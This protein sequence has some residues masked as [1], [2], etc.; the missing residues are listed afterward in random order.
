MV[1][2]G[3]DIKNA[4]DLIFSLD[5]G[6]KTVIGI[7]GIYENEKF[8]VI[9][10]SIKEHNRRNMYD[11]QIHDIEG[12]TK[13]VK[14]VKE[15]LEK[16]LEISLKK[17]SIAAAGRALKT[18]RLRLDKDIDST[19][20]IDNNMIKALELEAVQKSQESIDIEM[21]D[22]NL[23]YYS[24]GHSVI[25]YYLDNDFIER[26]EGHKGRKIGVDLLATFLPKVV[27]DSLYVVVNRAGLE[28]SNITLEPIAAINIAIK[29][30][31]RLLNLALVDIGAGTSD[32]AI[33][34]DGT[35]IAYA[36]AAIAGDEITENISKNYLLDFDSSEEL[37]VKLNKEK[38]HKFSDIVGI[39]YSCSSEEIISKIEK[40]IDKLATEIAKR[41]L[42]YNVKAPSA[43]FL[44]GGSSQIPLL[45]KYIAKYL[46]LPEERVVVRDLN[47]IENIEGI[48]KL[49][50]GPDMITPIGI[51]VEG[52]NNKDEN[53][54]QIYLNNEELR[55]FNTENVKVADVLI[56]TGHSPR[57][58][59]PERGDDF[60]YYLN[61]EKKTVKGELGTP[62]KIFI[63][64]VKGSLNTKL[65]NGDFVEIKDSTMG[66]RKKLYLYDHI[67]IE[68][69]IV[70][71]G[72][73]MKLLEKVKVNGEIVEKDTQLNEGDRIKYSK[74]ETLYDLLGD[75]DIDEYIIYKNG[76]EI[77][78]YEKLEDKDE[79]HIDKRS[80]SKKVD[81]N[82]KNIYLIVNGEEKNFSYT[83]EEFVFV[84]IFS[85][86]DFDL[87]K[88]KG[89][90]V[91]KV[92]NREA[93]YMEALESNDKV[94]V[95]WER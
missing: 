79:I 46:E 37:K 94:E 22:N 13:V 84:N 3:K 40:T 81:A 19:I 24:I 27:I 60:I 20:E 75:I 36:M 63:N 16:K 90:L 38:N 85:Y 42:E 73:G 76:N 9:A 34:K 62:A 55:V 74:V 2:L 80:R 41:I 83:E 71:N 48:S 69:K 11:G 4:E 44:I 29:E 95:Y 28:V 18:Y 6:T 64:G 21:K 89:K 50:K 61:D 15:E 7:V 78:I 51:A 59:I 14:E 66:E 17:V 93:Q 72:E 67:P 39:E 68:E 88:P 23:K 30:N 31:L 91:L 43:V 65:R 12:V 1:D 58:L 57:K 56:L 32:I 33:T 10:S 82:E 5:I 54:I 8:K 53:F 35:I 86:I 49:N 45:N 25:G 70:L 92:N 52:A 26:L 87:S 47:F 77:D